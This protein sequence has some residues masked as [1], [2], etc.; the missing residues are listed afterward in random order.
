MKYLTLTLAVI[1]SLAT[2]YVAYR[3]IRPAKKKKRGS[4]KTC[5]LRANDNYE[6]TYFEQGESWKSDLSHTWKYPVI[7][8][9]GFTSSKGT[10][11]AVIDF[12]PEQH[13][14]AVDL[15][16]HGSTT[17]R[18][19]DGLTA[20]DMAI[21]MHEFLQSLGVKRCH[22]V[23]HSLGAVVSVVY[24]ALYPD[25]IESLVAICPGMATEPH[26]TEFYKSVGSPNEDEMMRKYLISETIDDL[27]Y[28]FKV[29]FKDPSSVQI[30]EEHLSAYLEKRKEQNSKLWLLWKQLK[31]KMRMSIENKC[32]LYM[33]SVKCQSLVVWG[34][35]D[36]VVHPY[37][38]EIL[39]QG[40]NESGSCKKVII[41]ECG[42]SVTV[43]KPK[44]L[45]K[46]ILDFIANL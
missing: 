9:H 8:F 46:H 6:V 39:H 31:E 10:W 43:E 38:A 15:P 11:R 41:P 1:G 24:A 22:M 26:E 21:T 12:F 2:V 16:G 42:H 27:R 13:V 7:L 19:T 45:A 4:V 40:L 37:G 35:S 33:S 34:D 36:E 23:G 18:E 14:F 20:K 17:F 3:L 28:Q 25:E 29:M 44:V 32:N 30:P 5:K